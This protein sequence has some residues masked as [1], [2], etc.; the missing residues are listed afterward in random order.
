MLF[1]RSKPRKE[2]EDTHTA[3]I[4]E[5]ITF[6]VKRDVKQYLELGKSYFDEGRLEEALEQYKK[7]LDCDPGCALCH[8]NLGY[9][10]HEKGQYESAQACY[11]KAIE[12]EPTCSLFLEHLA[13]LEA[14]LLNYAEASRLFQRASMVGTIQP[15]SLGLWGRALFEQGKFEESIEAFQRLLRHNQRAEIEVGAQYWLAVSHTRLD[16]IAAARQITRE[17]LAHEHIE[18][19]ILFDL[20]ENFIEARCLSLA[21]TI[22]ERLTSFRE[23]YLSA[24]LRLEEIRAFEQQIDD[25]LPKLFEGDEERTLHQIHSLREYG[26]DRISRALMT[27]IHTPSAP[28]RE[29]IIRYQT[30]F[31]FDVAEELLPLL[32]DAVNYVRDAAYDYFEK[33]NRGDYVEY[34]LVGLNDT[35]FPI[36]QKAVNYLGR[37]A[38]VDVLPRLEMALTEPKNRTMQRD[39]R[40]AIFAIKKRYQETL[41]SLSQSALSATTQTEEPEISRDWR[42]WIFF[43]LQLTLVGYFIYF[44]FRL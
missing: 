14:E 8:F 11:E 17:L 4:S 20:A 12:I 31:G 35:Q 36:R 1:N 33:L 23:D 7:A 29:S 43:L 15:V 3:H 42:F 38:S 27:L 26:N 37:F 28:I 6:M 24:R 30:T 19:K 21:R 5:K 39:I 18:P 9:A 32:S 40:R 34:M 44:L 13:R 25:T 2:S 10:Y 16:R 41:D 22:L